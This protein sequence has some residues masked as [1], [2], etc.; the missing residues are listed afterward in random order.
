MQNKQCLMSVEKPV[1]FKM[2]DDPQQRFL[3]IRLLERAT[4]S[5][6][7]NLITATTLHMWN[8]QGINLHISNRESISRKTAHRQSLSLQA[9]QTD[10]SINV[11]QTIVCA[12]NHKPL[13]E[14]TFFQKASL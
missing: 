10:Q 11:V 14:Q 4:T 12:K 3:H 8:K 7:Y 5:Y 13:F 2:L 6:F 1:A 9:M